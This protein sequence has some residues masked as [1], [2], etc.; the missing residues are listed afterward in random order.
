M[1]KR[2]LL[3]E[4]FNGTN[5]L[6]GKVVCL[7]VF[8]TAVCVCPFGA[9]DAKAS[10][11]QN[12]RTIT[13]TVVDRN[14]EAIIGANIVE[15]GTT[16]GVV[17][18]L[19]GNFSLSVGAQ[20]TLIISYIGYNT[21]EVAVGNQTR[22]KVRLEENS[23]G[24]DEV[25]VVGY[26]TVSRKNL[27]TAISKISADDVPKVGNSNMSQLLLGRAAGLQATMASAQPGGNVEISIRGAG[28]APVFV[29]DGVVVPGESLEPSAGGLVT[30]TSISR[31]GLAG[32]N[33]EDIESIEVLKDASASI[34][35][36]GAANGVILVTTKRG[37]EGPVRI[38]YEGT[39]STVRNYAYP[40]PLNAQ[41]YM[42]YVNIFSK[43]QYL[44]NNKLS[45]YGPTD[46]SGGWAP[47]YT[48]AQIAEAR[49]TDWK[50]EIL[51]NGSI[52]NHTLTLNGGSGSFNYYV[53]GNY[54]NQQGSVV[55]SGMERFA[56]RSNM[57]LTLSPVVKL[58]LTMNI[59]NNSYLNSTV[60]GTSNGK[61]P[62]AAG[63]LSSA[64]TYPPYFP[65]KDENGKYSTFKTIPNAVG[66][67]DINDKTQMYGSY[68]NI[69]ADFVI[70]KEIL[71]AKALYGNNMENVRRSVYIPSDV[72]FE[73]MYKSRGNL[74]ENR[75]MNQTMEAT[76][77][78]NK[79][80]FDA[81]NVDLVA[82][83]GLYFNSAEGMNVTY[84]GQY[85][86]IANDNLG[87]V[88]GVV[89]PGSSRSK[90]E[91]RSQFLRANFDI[92]DRYVVSGTLRRDGTDKFFPDKKYA[93]FPA[94]SLAWKLSNEA[95]L[96]DVEWINLLKIRASYGKTGNDNLGTT[97]YGTYG[98]TS[99][100]VIFDNA[101]VK[102]VPISINGLDYPNV[103]WQK[104]IMKN[105]G[106]D[107]YL[108]NDRISGSLDVFRNDITDMLSTA[109]TA[110]LSMF[111][112]YPINGA[113]QRRSGWDATLNTKNILLRD[114]SWLSVLT[115]TKYNSLWIERMPNY[116]YNTY[117]KRGVVTTN[118][119][120]YYET[121]G[122]INMDKSNMPA[123]QPASAQMPGYPIIVDRNKDGEITIDDIKRMDTTPDLYLGFG[124]TFNYK[125][126]DLDLFIYSQL[127]VSK[128]NYALDWAIPTELSNE[129]SNGNLYVKRIWNSQTNPNGTLPGIASSLASVTLPG[130][131][132]TDARYQDASFL[133]VRNITLGYNFRG[134]QL[135]VAGKVIGNA[136]LYI[137][138]Q[139]PFVFTKFEGFDPE[140]YSGGNYKG[141]K[142][143]YPQTG[144]Y[145][146]GLKI[147][148]K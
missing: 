146:I 101:S 126:W 64:L 36:I 28:S 9:V 148:F 34:Y 143:E 32:L 21:M 141:G 96:E 26:G 118:A 147:S 22:L 113:H 80:F 142:A 50:N 13:G 42:T 29:V 136:R 63:A 11:Q 69:A 132:G 72:F 114:F 3:T 137:D 139:N 12:N 75:R 66:L 91:K 85:D 134:K 45:P 98:P 94:L 125:N 70:L 104:T 135:G 58:T 56:L 51:R 30:P 49:T 117:E 14:D 39:L 25:V 108:F 7:F 16:N 76:L 20:A 71:T 54:Y 89:S 121:D 24:L 74:A 131:A 107:F 105:V 133:R 4:L 43:E 10:P 81:V 122:Y 59:N 138:A 41:E 2:S 38:S 62:E 99:Q 100:Y 145:S 37:K 115:L 23:L 27:T 130:G 106:I 86:A 31:S 33:P 95:F 65:I 55:N 93:L 111:G 61:G 57:G 46:Y 144:I 79:R 129:N 47:L 35:G 8:A 102:Y 90:D 15:K 97:L 112:T 67:L 48:D 40:E 84:D 17:S 77:M 68:V 78:F 83:A 73:Q 120:Y 92:L 19:D 82:G 88:S 18:D 109:N 60:G 110:G 119:R 140:V 44:Y 127:G 87:S 128:H 116:D 52:S 1:E 123:S 6:C 124:N 5:R 103:T 53:S